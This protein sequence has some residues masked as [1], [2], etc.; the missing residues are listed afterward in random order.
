M[1][2]GVGAGWGREAA[3]VASMKQ[4]ARAMAREGAGKNSVLYDLKQLER[5]GSFLVGLFDFFFLLKKK[6]LMSL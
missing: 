2:L 3:F 6:I 5:C 1:R 4:G